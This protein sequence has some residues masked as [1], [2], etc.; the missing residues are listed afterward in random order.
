MQLRD[1][2]VLIQVPMG[3]GKTHLCLIMHHI[4]TKKC[5]IVVPSKHLVKQFLELT[6][7]E[8]NSI[9]VLTMT[10]ALNQVD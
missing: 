9:P 6:M 7:I 8:P 10:E 4:L 5:A 3:C 2:V 1:K